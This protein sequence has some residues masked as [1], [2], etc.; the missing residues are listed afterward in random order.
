MTKN[1]VEICSIVCSLH[2]PGEAVRMFLS[3]P[4]SAE[5]MV[6]STVNA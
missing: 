6:P 3:K 4:V 5:M 2:L 1:V